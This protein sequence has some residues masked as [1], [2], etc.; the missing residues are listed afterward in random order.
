MPT[1]PATTTAA[2]TAYHPVFE[3]ALLAFA[4]AERVV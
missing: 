4:A 3:R 1:I 2:I